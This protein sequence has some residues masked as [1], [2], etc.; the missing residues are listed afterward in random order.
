[1]LVSGSVMAKMNTN[2]YGM[3]INFAPLFFGGIQKQ[4]ALEP[5]LLV[6]R[7]LNDEDF[8]VRRKKFQGYIL[9]V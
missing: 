1:M 2:V 9:V 3:D 8:P 4:V 6:D 7:S 5:Q